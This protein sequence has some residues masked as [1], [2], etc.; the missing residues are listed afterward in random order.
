[1][2]SIIFREILPVLF[3]SLTHYKQS[4]LEKSFKW[5][6]ENVVFIDL[7]FFLFNFRFLTLINKKNYKYNK[8]MFKVYLKILRTKKIIWIGFSWTIYY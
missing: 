1:M 3:Y 8:I 7:L 4:R 6:L 5:S 2:S